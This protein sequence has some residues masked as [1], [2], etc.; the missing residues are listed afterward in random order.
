MLDVEK[1]KQEILQKTHEQIETEAAYTWAS[2]ACAAFEFALSAR[3]FKEYLYWLELYNDFKHEA[4]E[5][6]ALV[7]KSSKLLSTIL[8]L[9]EAYEEK[10]SKSK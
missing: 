6:S 3:D 10:I 2:R 9:M 1:A 5:H 7:E 4:I 8:Q